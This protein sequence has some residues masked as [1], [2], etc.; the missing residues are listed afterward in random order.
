MNPLVGKWEGTDADGS[1]NRLTI[2]R[3]GS[4]RLT[5][6]NALACSPDGFIVIDDVGEFRKRQGRDQLILRDAFADCQ[7]G[8]GDLTIPELVI[9]HDPVADTVRSVN[10]PPPGTIFRRV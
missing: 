9:E 10:E 5:D 7:Q 4:L 2:R 1:T 3:D 8:S 6:D